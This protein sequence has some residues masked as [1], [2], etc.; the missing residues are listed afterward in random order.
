MP[1]RLRYQW[2]RLHCATSQQGAVPSE[3][4][5]IV[6]YFRDELVAYLLING[7]VLCYRITIASCRVPDFLH[8]RDRVIVLHSP[9]VGRLTNKGHIR[10]DECVPEPLNIDPFGKLLSSRSFRCCSIAGGFRS[11]FSHKLLF[12][13][14]RS[15]Y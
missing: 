1:R 5:H 9:R 4:H 7:S 11:F 15:L 10:R 3:T 2:I 6:T 13:T 8:D 14:V 12:A